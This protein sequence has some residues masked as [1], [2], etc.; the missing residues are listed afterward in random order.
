MLDTYSIHESVRH[1]IGCLL[2]SPGS[3][4]GL[5]STHEPARQPV[6]MSKIFGCDTQG[7]LVCTNLLASNMLASPPGVYVNRR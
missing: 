5:A 3:H 7:P 1:S 2:G 6:S 4:A